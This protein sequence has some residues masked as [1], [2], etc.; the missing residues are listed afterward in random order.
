MIQVEIEQSSS[1]ER[2]PNERAPLH[3]VFG[4]RERISLGGLIGATSSRKTRTRVQTRAQC[5]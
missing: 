2:Q 4:A 3:Q 1:N 5:A